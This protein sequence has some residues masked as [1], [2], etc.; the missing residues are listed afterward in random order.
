MGADSVDQEKS[1]KLGAITQ[2]DKEDIARPLRWMNKL[3]AI[4]VPVYNTGR[5]K[6]GNCIRSIIKQ[7]YRD[8]VLILIDDGSTD[9]SGR[10]CDSFAEKDSRV[11]VIHQVNKGSV[12]ARK[13]GVSCKEAQSAEYI[14]FCDSDDTMPTNALEKLVTTAEQEQADCVCGKICRVYNNISLP[15]QNSPQCFA[16]EE[17]T[18]YSHAE[19]MDKLYVS[20]FGINNYPVSLYAKLYRT[21]LITQASDYEPIVRFM[22][23]DLSVTLRVLPQTKRLAIISDT[24]YYYHIGGGTSR[25]MP[26]MMDDFL[27]LY[28]FKKKMAELHPMPQN[29]GYLM[30]VEL[31]N[32]ALSWLESCATKGKYSEDAL[33]EEILRVCTLP[34]VQEAMQQKD[35]TEKEPEGVRKAIQDCDTAKLEKLIQDRIARRRLRRAIKAILK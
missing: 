4:I 20:C 30:A 23:D 9:D 31:K 2:M 26:Y 29:T 17:K 10:I 28:R 3:I 35:F 33:H 13:T 22:G 25:F 12:E 1:V 7:T 14:C 32:I 18:V 11:K 5:K 34:E 27:S 15:L 21:E 6:L 24:V 19:I 16:D 8:Y